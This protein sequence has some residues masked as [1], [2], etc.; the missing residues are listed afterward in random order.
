MKTRSMLYRIGIGICITIFF[1]GFIFGSG[2]TVNITNITNC[3][4]NGSCNGSITVSVSGGV[5][6]FTYSWNTSPAQTNATATGLCAGT[7][8]CTVIDQSDMSSAANAGTVTQP[9]QLNLSVASIVA[10]T[11]GYPNGSASV[12]AGGGTPSYTYNWVPGGGTAASAN[13]LI[14]G[15]YTVTVTDANGC[16]NAVSVVVPNAPGPSVTVSSANATCICNGSATANVSGGTAPY[17]Y[18]WT[19][20]FGTNVTI[21]GLCNGNYTVTVTDANGCTANGVATINGSQGTGISTSS[22]NATCGNSNG[23]ASVTVTSGVPPYT[24]SWAPVNSTATTLSNI[25]GGTYTVTV[26]GGTGCSATSSVIV[27]NIG[28]PNCT[29]SNTNVSCNGM[30]NGAS[31]AN[32]SGGV[33]PYTFSWNTGATTNSISNL[34]AGNYTVAVT[35]NAGCT[36]IYA[37]VINQPG[38]LFVSATCAASNCG[39]NGTATLLPTGGTLPYSYSWS[40]SPVQTSATA[41][42]LSAGSYPFLVTDANGCT[43]SASINVTGQCMSLVRGKVFNDMNGNC[44]Q[45]T[46]ESGIPGEIVYNGT[47]YTITDANGDYSLFTSTLNN[48]VYISNLPQYAIQ[49]CPS[50]NLTVNFSNQGDTINNAD[51]GV[52]IPVNNN[53]IIHPGWT[54]SNPGFQKH[55]WIYWYNSGST[56]QNATIVFNYDSNLVYQNCTL[57]G[58]VDTINHTITWNFNNVPPTAGWNPQNKPDIYFMVPVNMNLSTR[59][60]SRF[61]IDPIIGDIHPGDNVVLDSGMVTGSRDPNS[62][63]VEPEGNGPSGLISLNDTTFLYTIHF[64][65]NGNDTCF[66]VVVIDTL[67]SY[68]NPATVIPGA[69]DHPY[70]FSMSGNAVLT[71]RFDN[72]LLPDSGTNEP[73]SNGYLNFTIHAKPTVQPGDVIRNHA[74]IYF[75]FNPAV[76]TDTTINTYALS[77][78]LAPVLQTDP[79]LTVFPNPFS[80]HTVLYFSDGAAS[81]TVEL[82]DVLGNKVRTYADV[83]QKQCII[84]KEQL[85]SG[86]Y[87]YKVSTPAGCVCTGKLVVE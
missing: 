35:D 12:I 80:D 6:P 46:G 11:C 66:T 45:E 40:T 79:F 73:A 42:G 83:S 19:T 63:H 16:T 61:E 75:D 15:S 26:T 76:I 69:A 3:L 50:N 70:T 28:G 23:S 44:V 18:S 81:H 47:S 85:R 57:N 34:V 38:T 36:N 65:N 4:C 84:N 25:P 54:Q 48:Q 62:K 14:P 39:N 41:T 72:I 33:P 1:P 17:T 7:Y 29:F 53:F 8:T 27:N 56:A 24:Y 59:L 60:H 2:H 52:Q 10:A 5:G 37:T 51:F 49:V 64:Q 20:V 86:I 22:T 58:I 21:S 71:W 9:S 13:G 55:Y 67:P 30:N 68:L 82:F 87:F 77:T 43:F 74:F 31:T 32:A 78:A